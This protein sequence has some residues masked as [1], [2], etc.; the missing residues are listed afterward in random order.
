MRRVVVVGAGFGGLYAVRALHRAP[1]DITLIDRRNHHLFQPLLYQVATATLNASDIASPIRSILRHQKNAR[2]LLGEVVRIDLPGKKVVLRDGLEL[3]YDYL[4]LATGSTDSYFGHDEWA[5]LAPSLK[6]V[7]DALEIRRRVFSA[8]EVAER[9]E[10]PVARASLLTFVIVGGGPTGVELA[11]A[12]AEIA[13]HSLRGDFRSI[14]PGRS[15]VVL[16]EGMPRV[17]PTYDE[18]L[19]RKAEQRLRGLGIEVHTGARVTG[20]DADGVDLGQERIDARTVIWA[21]GVAASPLTGSLGVPLD[22]RGRVPVEPDLRI[23]GRDDAFVVGDLAAL[24]SNGKPVPGVSPAAIQ[25]G[26]QTA[27][28]IRRLLR[29][30]PTRAFHYFD[31]GEFAVIGRGAAV[32]NPFRRLKIS[33][34]SAWLAWLFIHL[35]FLIGYRNRL[36]VL[37]D[38]AYSY[39]TFRRGAALITGEAPRPERLPAVP[40]AGRAVP[41]AKPERRPAEPRAGRAAH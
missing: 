31:K 13:Q 32:G 26:R 35:Y 30:Q 17:L 18:V 39:L 3:G 4:V 21:A 1:V 38:W 41:S 40:D 20:V 19:S 10:D 7:E 28:N 14:D 36:L 29:G 2:V 6:S 9:T 8:F 22:R 27:A 12:L 23:S 16:V 24:K 25:E 5:P 34:F 11:G 37:I 33:G 15:R